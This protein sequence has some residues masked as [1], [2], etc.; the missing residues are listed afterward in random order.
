MRQESWGPIS[1]LDGSCRGEVH[2][3]TELGDEVEQ[4]S[5]R[6]RDKVR[7]NKHVSPDTVKI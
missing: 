4:A 6:H 1:G 7:P 5:L 3:E 2:L